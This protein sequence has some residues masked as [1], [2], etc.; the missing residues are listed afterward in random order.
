MSRVEDE[1]VCAGLLARFAQCLDAR[2]YDSLLDLVAEDC[3]W[4]GGKDAR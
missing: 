3:V 2:D 4:R 1:F